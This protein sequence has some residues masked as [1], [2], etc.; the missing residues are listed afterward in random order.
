M[1]RKERQHV[2]LA[3]GATIGDDL[4]ADIGGSIAGGA[5]TPATDVALG[6]DQLRGVR[7][8]RLSLTDVEVTVAA[9][10]D[11]GGTKL[12]DLPDSNLMLLAV[13]VNLELT[14]GL[15]TNGIVGTTDVTVG[16][17]TA[18]ASNATLS[19]AM[20]NVLS[21]AALT[22]TDETPAYAAH[23]Q[24]DGTLSYPVQLA[25]SATL[26][27][28]LNVAAAITADDSITATGTVDLFFV[29]T[30]NVTS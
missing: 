18:V 8:V 28:Y 20:V 4:K 29:D 3:G 30:G 17:G 11:Y 5:V 10:D 25:D 22:A 14:K 13:E 6:F 26:A 7:H 1:T 24:A 27:L 19:G 23:S 12:A 21:G 9:A 15:A 16:L 2:Y